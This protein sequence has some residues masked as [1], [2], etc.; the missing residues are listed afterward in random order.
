MLHPYSDRV[1]HSY[2]PVLVFQLLV[3]LKLVVD[4]ADSSN[5]LLVLPGVGYSDAIGPHGEER[6]RSCSNIETK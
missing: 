5:K 3:Q 2:T 1:F 6:D 4:G